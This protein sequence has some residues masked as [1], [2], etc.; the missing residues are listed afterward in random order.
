MMNLASLRDTMQS[1]T[2]ANKDISFKQLQNVFYQNLFFK[3]T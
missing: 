2:I 1:N 3:A